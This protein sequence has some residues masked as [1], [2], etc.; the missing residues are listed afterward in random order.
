MSIKEIE[1]RIIQEAEAE[2]AKINKQVEQQIKQLDQVNT[3][4]Q[5]EVKAQIRQKAEQKA[6]EAAK[7]IV[8][9]ARLEARKTILEE[10]QKAFSG[11]YQEVRKE[12][13]LSAAE[14]DKIRE[15]TEV[16]AAKILFE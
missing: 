12:K 14:I 4:K 16:K 11:I 1:K 7:A 6:A 15:Q 2:A 10:K 5:Q 13:K 9:P 8:V 3:R